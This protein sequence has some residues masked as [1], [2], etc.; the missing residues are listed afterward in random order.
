[1]SD[2]DRRIA[3]DRIEADRAIL[4]VGNEQVEIPAA[5]LPPGTVEGALLELKLAPRADVLEEAAAR[6]ERLRAR[7]LKPSGPVDL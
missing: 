5:F 2:N 7:S 1:M 3:L 6:L 4:M